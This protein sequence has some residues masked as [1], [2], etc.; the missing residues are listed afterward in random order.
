MMTVWTEQAV[1]WLMVWTDQAVRWLM[2]MIWTEMDVLKE[3]DLD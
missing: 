1:R 2:V 3:D